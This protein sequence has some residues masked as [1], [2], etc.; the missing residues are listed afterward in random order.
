VFDG[1][2]VQAT[3]VASGA[4]NRA[5]G[6]PWVD[7]SIAGSCSPP[8]ITMTLM[9]VSFPVTPGVYSV[10]PVADVVSAN[11]VI[12]GETWRSSFSNMAQ[13][14][15]TGVSSVLP[16]CSDS[17]P[18][19]GTVTVTSATAQ[20]ISG[21]FHF[22]MLLPINYTGPLILRPPPITKV[23][24]GSFDLGFSNRVAC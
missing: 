24:D 15:T 22:V 13:Y 19:S 16:A 6:L 12:G 14:C 9:G 10:S 23:V 2:V 21:S 8:G 17:S 11:A 7:L 3:N 4:F 5:P 18:A 20:R 1:Q